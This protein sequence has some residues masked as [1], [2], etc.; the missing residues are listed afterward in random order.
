MATIFSNYIELNRTFSLLPKNYTQLAVNDQIDIS[1]ALGITVNNEV[2]WE[3]LIENYR[4][5]ILSEAGAGKTEEICQQCKK[6]RAEGKS[7][8]FMRLEHVPDHFDIAF[9]V[10]DYDEFEIWLESENEGWLLLD[11]IDE[12]KLKDQKDFERAIRIISTKINQALYRTHIVL[13]GRANY[14]RAKTDL[15]LCNRY[16][17]YPT[18]KTPDDDRYIAFDISSANDQDMDEPEP[19]ENTENEIIEIEV[20]SLTNLSPEQIEVFIQ[21]KGISDV[22]TFLDEI[23]RYDA[24]EL[25]TRPQDLE[26]LVEYWIEKGRFGSR[27]ELMNNTIERRLRERDQDRANTETISRDKLLQGVRLLAT[28][29]TLMHENTI[30]IPDGSNSTQGINP[31]LLL[32]EW[33]Q[34]EC[35]TLLGRP[36]FDEAIYGTVRFHHRTVR[37]LLTAQWLDDVLK[38][39]GSRRMVENLFFREQYGIEFVRPSMAPVLSWMVI[40]DV[41]I[42]DISKH[43][44]PEVI[45]ECADPSHLPIDLRRTILHSVCNNISSE[46][47]SR[48]EID[49]TAIQR[50]T[51]INHAN[52]IKELIEQYKHDSEITYILMRMIWQGQIIDN[53][54]EAKS[55]AVDQA[56]ENYTR[57]AAIRAVKE[58][59]NTEDI[60]D[61]MHS[62]TEQECPV[63]RKIL[64]EM[65]ECLDISDESID[66][67]FNIIKKLEDYDPYS[68]SGLGRAL[69]RLID[70][71]DDNLLVKFV[72]HVENLLLQKPVI[73][74]RHCEV[75]EQFSWL[76]GCG[77]KAVKKLIISRNSAALGNEALTILVKAPI[78]KY[79]LEYEFKFDHGEFADLVQSWKE[80]NHRLF[81]HHM[82]LTR[83][84]LDHKKG[85]R[86]TEV[87]RIL[88]DRLWHFSADDFEL[89]KS[90]I[91][92]RDF[93]DDKLVALDLAF[94]IYVEK[95]R[96]RKWRES[97]KKITSDHAELQ[98]TLYGLL[99]PPPLTKEQKSS[100][101][102]STL[103]EQRRKRR[104]QDRK[105]AEADSK[106]WLLA[107]YELIRDKKIIEEGRVLNAHEVLHRKMRQFR[108][109]SSSWTSGNWT[110]LIEDYGQN[111]AEAFRDYLT[112][113]WKFNK[114]AFQSE[115]KSYDNSIYHTNILGLSGLA[116]TARENPDWVVELSQQEVE[117]VCRYAF[118]ELNHFPPWFHSF[119]IHHSNSIDRYIIQEITWEIHGSEDHYYVLSK[120]VNGDEWLYEKLA[121]DLYN[122]LSEEPVCLQL[123]NKSLNIIQSGSV[124]SDDEIINL[125]S[126]K[127]S[128]LESPDHL[129]FWYAVWVGVDPEK[130]IETLIQYIESIHPGDNKDFVMN[131]IVNL[132]GERTKVSNVRLNY[133]TPEHLKSLYLLLLEFIKLDEDIHRENTGAYTPGLRDSAQEARERIFTMLCNIPGKPTYLILMDLSESH[134]NESLK[135]WMKYKARLRAINDAEDSPFSLEQ[136]RD[137]SHE[138]E[139]IPANHSQLF[140]LAEHRLLDLKDDLEQGDSSNAS[141]LK[142][143]NEEV[144]IRKFIGN[145]CRDRAS[146]KYS[147]PQEEEFADARRPD[148]RFHSSLF[149]APVPLELKL[150]D[151]WS[152][153]ALFERLENQLC[154]D[155]IRDSR[156]TRGIYLLVYR[157]EKKYWE[158]QGSEQLNFDAL[159]TSL[160]EKAHEIVRQ[161]PDIETISVIGIDLTIRKND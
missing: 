35:C 20:Y 149:D 105:K 55:F 74:K 117:L 46:E 114:P 85:E 158:V 11:S 66:W 151:N 133:Q 78:S 45:F 146:G 109:D 92:D 139:F 98:S 26:E 97:L 49:Y 7:A 156:S 125:A 27:L 10:G 118:H 52:D 79:Y 68:A 93:L 61:V 155:Y 96:P 48:S 22:N 58:I 107:N 132:I 83:D 36:I 53:L 131:F 147:V 81:W 141:I 41:K 152:G 88:Y 64:A 18:E 110:D 5:V 89:I 69:Q 42:R 99:H 29:T 67:L 40:F 14:W 13:T 136:F 108:E 137:Y 17:P 72:V 106:E 50:F 59:G 90:D 161:Q 47:T 112:E 4:V 38:N 157:G 51:D 120:I 60:N 130:G 134:P 6:L 102:E 43:I 123:L 145:W 25:T 21:A 1:K 143:I 9:E 23:E 2:E 124:I 150:A 33:T 24:W 62:F 28:A 3:K 71:L 103:Y 129:A 63:E 86:L 144:E 104:K 140:M 94:R 122:L 154:G 16:L 135:S 73:E 121:N 127:C 75:S 37:E 138:V 57:I 80:L 95:G 115:N 31:A 153:S 76:L 159:V 34:K 39:E 126:N 148:L 128:S 56:S 84:W 12:S 87:W 142:K 82:K 101:R 19:V 8:F 77:V 30:T 15:D 111:V 119:Y 116:I 160:R 54:P 70:R 32:S 113:F 44:R 65:L 100:R 91:V